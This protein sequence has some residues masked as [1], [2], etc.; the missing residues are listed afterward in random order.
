MGTLAALLAPMAY[1]FVAAG[2]S[3]DECSASCF[4][5]TDKC[6]VKGGGSI[7]AGR[8]YCTEDDKDGYWCEDPSKIGA[9][10]ILIALAIL[11][12]FLACFGCLVRHGYNQDKEE[13]EAYHRRLAEAN[14]TT[15]GN[16]DNNDASAK[17]KTEPT[18]ATDREPT[19][20]DATATAPAPASAK[21]ATARSKSNQQ[22][23][24][25]PK[26]LEG[27]MASQYNMKWSDAKSSLGKA[28]EMFGG[29]IDNQEALMDAAYQIHMSRQASNHN[30]S[31]TT[32]EPRNSARKIEA[33]VAADVGYTEG[34]VLYA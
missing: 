28:R 18:E 32:P 5:Q 8:C 24:N 22:V 17:E 23:P 3:G 4:G 20:H 25:Q 9:G 30:S 33:P 10:G 21:P 13:F 7:C 26:P 14:D 11:L 16:V 1:F 29:S 15:N 27:K 12:L 2:G 31:R 6:C 34:S 19:E